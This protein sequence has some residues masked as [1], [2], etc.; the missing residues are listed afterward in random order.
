MISLS[1]A[2]HLQTAVEPLSNGM[3]LNKDLSEHSS[4]IPGTAPLVFDA[5]QSVSDAATGHTSIAASPATFRPTTSVIERARQG[6]LEG[7]PAHR[8]DI[9]GSL[10][11]HEQQQT[12]DATS[13]WTAITS[14][15][16]LGDDAELIDDICKLLEVPT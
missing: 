4:N 2:N 11:I 16:E 8:I 5:S 9:F 10:K 1:A 13:T 3:D 6:L 7:D 12:H 14:E 15:I